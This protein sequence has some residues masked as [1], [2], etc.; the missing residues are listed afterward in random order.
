[1][2]EAL[3]SATCTCS[4]SLFLII[5]DTNNSLSMIDWGSM[6]MSHVSWFPSQ[7]RFIHADKSAPARVEI[8]SSLTVAGPVRIFFFPR[9]N[10]C[11]CVQE[12]T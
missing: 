11:A 4:C 8:V 10:S 7:L 5:V 6:L 3:D 9:R 1:M 2:N 12:P